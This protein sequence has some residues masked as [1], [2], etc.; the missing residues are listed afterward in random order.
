MTDKIAL[1]G[2]VATVSPAALA[3]N[4]ASWLVD[5]GE[6]APGL[7]GEVRD[8]QALLDDLHWVFRDAVVRAGA[9][10]E[11]LPKGGAPELVRLHDKLLGLVNEL[12]QSLLEVTDGLGLVVEEHPTN[13]HLHWIVDFQ[14]LGVPLQAVD[15]GVD[16]VLL[17]VAE[18]DLGAGLLDGD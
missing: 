3:M 10:F 17:E 5:G 13:G 7:D 6:F 12:S 16:R 8:L 18:L 14:A 9:R 2:G 15:D 11:P 1:V 4:I